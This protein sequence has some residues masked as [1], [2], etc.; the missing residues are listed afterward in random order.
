MYG[1]GE[2]GVEGHSNS[3]T[4]RGVFGK[5]EAL[6]G[7]TYGVRGACNSPTGYGVYSL[8]DIGASGVKSFRIDH[9]F[10]P[11]NKYLLR[12]SSESPFPQNFYSGNIVTDAQGYAWVE[13]PS[14]FAQ[15]NTNFKYILTVVDNGDSNGFVM[16]K[17]SKKIVGNRF[18]ILTSQPHTE[19]SWDVKADRNDRLI[20]AHRVVHRVSRCTLPAWWA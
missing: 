14:Y 3:T 13:L 10:D 11:E 19:V 2:F 5:A 12:Y 8:G 4:R 7:V 17:I 16:A 15:I 20:Q 18:Q 1:L 6:T 9:P